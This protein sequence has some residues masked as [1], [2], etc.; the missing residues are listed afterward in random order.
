MADSTIRNKRGRP[1]IEKASL[2]KARVQLYNLRDADAAIRTVDSGAWRHANVAREAAEI[3]LEALVMSGRWDDA[4]KRFEALAA[5]PDSVLAVSGKYGRGMVLFYRGE[6]DEAATVLSEVAKEATWSKWANDALATAVLVKRA[7]EEDPA[8]LASFAA[9]MSADGSGRYGEAADSLAAAAS[10]SPRSVLAPE[11]FYES[12][13]LL[14]Q[15]GRRA[16]SIAMLE[17]IAETYPLSRSAPRA[18]ETLAA[19]REEDDPDEAVRWYALFLDRYGDDP[20]ATRVRS[21]YM[22][23]RK[24]MEGEEETGET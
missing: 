7:A 3:R 1:Y 20:W 24:S 4:T 2:I 14:E 6:F 17:K 18:V 8:V 13:L 10:R 12:A 15:A 21:S 11:A 16:E 22:R 5:S 9:A 19:I 23:L